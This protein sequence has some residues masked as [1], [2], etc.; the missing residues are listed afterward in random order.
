MRRPLR[1]L[2]ATTIVGSSIAVYLV[3]F[4]PPAGAQTTGCT[5][6][7]NGTDAR[8]YATPKT[9]LRVRGNSRVAV[10]GTALDLFF[11]PGESRALTYLVKLELA[12]ASWTV[13][14]GVSNGQTWSGSVNVADYATR[15]QGIY[16]VVA[17]TKSSQGTECFGRAYVKVEGDGGPLSTTAG[18][19][20]AGV[21]LVGA[22]GAAAAGARGGREIDEGAV[23]DAVGDFLEQQA[24]GPPPESPAA[25]DEAVAR[26]EMERR[27]AHELELMKFCLPLVVVAAVATIRAVA[28][29]VGHNLAAA[30]GGI[31]R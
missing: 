6:T 17:V 23:K 18:Q 12:G 8:R 21:G 20:A 11:A 1:L 26:A 19:V 7:L 25:A 2:A 16:K 31:F 24:G 14:S 30:I 15:G 10:T 9:A 29:D 22:A 4:A 13:T 3:A 28:S 5:A 27:H